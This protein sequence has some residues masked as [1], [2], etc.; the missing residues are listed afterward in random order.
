MANRPGGESPK[1]NEGEQVSAAKLNKIADMVLKRITGTHPIRA[2]STLGGIV[3]SLADIVQRPIGG[4]GTPVKCF[5]ITANNGSG[6][7]EGVEYDEPDGTLLGDV[8]DP[9]FLKED[10]LAPDVPEDAWVRCYPGAGSSTSP[11]YWF[12]LPLGCT[13]E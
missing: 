1:F 11:D 6:E 5:K 4:S 9:K 10:N 2:V 12:N 7:Y 8:D 13:T 3:L